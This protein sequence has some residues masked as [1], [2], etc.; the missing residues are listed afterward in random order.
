MTAGRSRFR[1][2]QFVVRKKTGSRLWVLIA[3]VLIVDLAVGA[4]R[5][6]SAVGR[7]YKFELQGG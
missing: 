1:V 7:A 6:T 4:T 2:V 5:V 3:F